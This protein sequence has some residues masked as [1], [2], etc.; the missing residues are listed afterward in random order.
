MGNTPSAPPVPSPTPIQPVI[1]V[2]LEKTPVQDGASGLHY[3]GFVYA[4]QAQQLSS[5]ICQGATVTPDEIGDIMPD[6]VSTDTLPV[7]PT[8]NRIS[9][10]ALQAY[11]ANFMN[12]G[13]IPG[14]LG[15]FKDQMLLDKGFYELIQMEY[16]WYETRYKAALQQFI[17]LVSDQNGGD[18]SAILAT[19]ISLNKRLNSL[20]E[21]VNYVGNYRATQVNQR[22]PQ[23]VKA[24]TDIQK[25]ISVLQE[26]QEYL[27]TKNVHIKT[28]E[29][30]VRYSAEKSRAMNIQIM[31]FVA[32]NVV[33]LGTVLTVYK[34]IGPKPM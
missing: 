18:S 8:T 21:I 9:A 12:T 34:G 30:M 29:E 17:T 15:D 31:F 5:D 10:S 7:D 28:Q 16:C 25:K 24:N 23:I 22:G 20:L 3:S 4:N 6:S 32:L 2:P 33:A 1:T 11:V 26:Q 27:G 13:R 19:T 14:E